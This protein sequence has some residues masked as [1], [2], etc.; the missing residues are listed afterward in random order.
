MQMRSVWVEIRGEARPTRFRHARFEAMGKESKGEVTETR[1]LWLQLTGV[2][3]ERTI[4]CTNYYVILRFLETLQNE[5]KA[6]MKGREEVVGTCCLC[7]WV[8]GLA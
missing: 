3:A 5:I 7:G 8:V 2:M 6:R 4:V 1:T